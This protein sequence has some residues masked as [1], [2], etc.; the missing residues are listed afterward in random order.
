MFV[1][2]EAFKESLHL[3]FTWSVNY[4]SLCRDIQIAEELL[5]RED[6]VQVLNKQFYLYV[7]QLDI[8]KAALVT[9]RSS[10]YCV[11]ND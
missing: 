6:Y 5:V 11:S 1:Q 4:S 8:A 7:L 3:P 10:V 2:R 9:E